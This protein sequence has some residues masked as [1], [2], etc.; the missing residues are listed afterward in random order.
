M[1]RS[2]TDVHADADAQVLAMMTA[3]MRADSDA[4]SAAIEELVVRG[5]LDA[6]TAEFLRDA[7]PRLLAAGAALT[8]VLRIHRCMTGVRGAQVCQNCGTLESCRTLRHVETSLHAYRGGRPVQIDRG[9]AWRRADAWLNR[10]AE[11]PVL[12]GVEE[13]TDGF[14]AWPMTREASRQPTLLIVDKRTGRLTRWPSL[15][16]DVLAIRYRSFLRDQF[17]KTHQ[18]PGGASR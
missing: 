10:D 1:V 5:R 8:G 16:K 6:D 7:R 18:R 13:F 4:I 14:V 9:E 11:R 3:A 17:M 12:V 2:A 15:P